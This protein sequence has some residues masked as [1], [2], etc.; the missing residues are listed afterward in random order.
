MSHHW[1]A[2]ILAAGKSTRAGEAKLLRKYRDVHWA[3]HLVTEWQ[4]L[5]AASVIIVVRTEEELPQQLLQ[6]PGVT[7]LRNDHWEWG[8]LYSAKLGI[9]EAQRQSAELVLLSPVDVPPPCEALVRALLT[10][11]DVPLRPVHR[12]SGGHPV[13]IPKACYARVAAANPTAKALNSV[14]HELGMRDLETEKS[15]VLENL[16]TRESWEQWIQD[17]P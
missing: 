6:L 13:L 3:R 17:N 10:G 1:C 7:F 5:G 4:R 15:S 2:V 12:G 8:P 9:D 16:N 11:D 14:L